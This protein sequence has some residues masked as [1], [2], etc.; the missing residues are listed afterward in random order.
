MNEEMKTL[1]IALLV[2]IIQGH[3]TPGSPEYTK[4]DIEKC[5]WCTDAESVIE[6]IG[7]D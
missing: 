1:C 4:C 5:T 7:K 2:E 3:K 6:S